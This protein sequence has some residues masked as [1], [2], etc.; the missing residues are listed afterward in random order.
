MLGLEE[1]QD[2]KDQSKGSSHQSGQP[3]PQKGIKMEF[4]S[5][6][7]EYWIKVTLTSNGIE[8]L[9]GDYYNYIGTDGSKGGVKLEKGKSWKTLFSHWSQYLQMD[10]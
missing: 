3:T 6:D 5:L 9:C 1:N 7:K 8:R 2:S 4:Y 10:C